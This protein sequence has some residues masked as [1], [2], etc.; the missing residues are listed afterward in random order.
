MEDSEIVRMFWERRETAIVEVKKKY[1]SLIC[2]LI[3][4]IVQNTEDVEECENDTYLGAWNCI[5]PNNPQNLKCFLLRIARNQALKRYRY[6][7]AARRSSKMVVAI[8]ELGE[9][10]DE[11]ESSHT[12]EEL[13]Q[14]INGFLA[15]LSSQKRRVFLLRY[16]YMESVQEIMGKCG[17]GK[18]KVET[19]LFRMRKELKEYLRERGYFYEA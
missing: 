15:S 13:A 4:R 2:G 12:D 8:E 6:E 16:W 10:A 7:N 9:I 11:R 5:P 3:Y 18:S 1:H 14:L 19:M 17:F